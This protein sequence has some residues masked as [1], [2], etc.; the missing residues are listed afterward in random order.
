MGRGERKPPSEH[1]ADAAALHLSALSALGSGAQGGQGPPETTGPA[2]AG[3]PG[4]VFSGPQWDHAADQRG[5]PGGG[6]ACVSW[7]SCATRSRSRALP[8]PCQLRV[9]DLAAGR[10]GAKGGHQLLGGRGKAW[11]FSRLVESQGGF[12][13]ASLCAARS[14]VCSQRHRT[15]Q[16]LLPSEEPL[17][18]GCWSVTTAV[19]GTWLR[20]PR[21]PSG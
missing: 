12:Q 11:E 19:T 9:C 3:F 5:L 13:A 20:L 15:F 14:G 21:R 16:K 2:R 10:P 8:R 18:E 1:S 6:L 4:C 17:V 7:G